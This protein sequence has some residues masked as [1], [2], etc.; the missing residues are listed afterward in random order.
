M[1]GKGSGVVGAR[2]GVVG[3]V[4]ISCCVC[5]T[6]EKGTPSN[7][8]G[9]QGGGHRHQGMHRHACPYTGLVRGLKE[10]KG[11]KNME[12]FECIL[13]CLCLFFQT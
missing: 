11:R 1:G 9:R 13:S 4:Q 5:C 6:A 12:A 2:E 8:K 10:K 3:R 7:N